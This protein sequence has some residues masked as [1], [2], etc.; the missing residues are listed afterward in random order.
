M[1][2]WQR[3]LHAHANVL[4]N[5]YLWRAPDVEHELQ[6]L[7]A[8]PLFLAQRAAIRARV[9]AALGKLGPAGD[10]GRE[11][12]RFFGAAENFLGSQAIRLVAVGGFSGSGKSTL[13]QALAPQIGRAP[14]AVHL[15]S[16]IERKRLA[17]V[18][19]YERL[20]DAAYGPETSG[21]IYQR[22]RHLAE[23]ALRA[24]QSVV[25]DA[26]HATSEERDALAAIAART[27]AQFIGL[28]LDA[29]IET[30]VSRVAARRRDASDATVA[31]VR[32][33]CARPLGYFDW[34]RL[35]ATQP[36]AE[37]M[38]TSLKNIG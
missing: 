25:V 37:L 21:K 29:P 3:D 18:G 15:R 14:G 8:L 20:S 19:E 12:R 34:V 13:A 27:G 2:L 28:W 10:H 26:V 36:L 1:D 24:G 9:T 4:F 11:A 35:D 5:R 38:E 31:V 30:L 23:I 16:D 17:G 7:A 33:Q 32:E 22:L 6:S